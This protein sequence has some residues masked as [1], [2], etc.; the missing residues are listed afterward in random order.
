[1]FYSSPQYDL[2]LPWNAYKYKYVHKC[3]QKQ[4]LQDSTYLCRA[5]LQT[6][7]NKIFCSNETQMNCLASSVFEMVLLLEV[8]A[9][10]SFWSPLLL[11]LLPPECTVLLCFWELSVQQKWFCSLPNIYVDTVLIS[12][13]CRQLFALRCLVFSFQTLVV[14]EITHCSLYGPIYSEFPRSIALFK[15]I[16]IVTTDS[17][18][19][20]YSMYG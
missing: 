19:P 20:Q 3:I 5:L 15:C 6:V 11:S 7:R 4:S 18:S 13:L 2:F 8:S 1:M 17:S 16:V 9:K 12:G 10:I 14:S